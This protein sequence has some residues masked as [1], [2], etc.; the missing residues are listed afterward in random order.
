MEQQTPRIRGGQIKH[1]HAVEGKRTKEH[2]AWTDMRGRCFNPKN[3]RYYAYGARGITVTKDWEKFE[4]FLADMGLCPKG[5]SLHRKNND[6]NYNKENCIWA[7]TGIQMQNRQ[8]KKGT[9]K[10]YG[11]SRYKNTKWRAEGSFGGAH[12]HLG[13]FDIEE[14]AAIAYDAA[15]IAH[16]GQNAG[17]KLNFP[18]RYQ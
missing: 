4:N 15:V 6:K 18:E 8:K 7:T 16:Y 13:F 14:D 11:V 17:A 3:Q 5:L 2:R 10:F 12:K 9:S 1:G